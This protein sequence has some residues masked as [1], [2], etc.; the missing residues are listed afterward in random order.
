M[1]RW[2]RLPAP[3]KLN[4]LL[5]IT[6]RRPDGYHLL[7]SVIEPIDWMDEVRLRRRSDG[8]VLRRQGPRWVAAEHD[9][10]VRAARLLQA[11]TGTRQGVE[12]WIRK[13]VPSGAGLGGGSA[14]AAAVLRGLNRLWKLGLSQLQLEQLGLQLGTDLPALLRARPVWAQ[15]LGEQL[16]EIE[17]P[18]RHYVVLFPGVA[19]ATATMYQSPQL[20]RDSPALDLA[21]WQSNPVFENAFEPVLR[22]AEPGVAAALDWLQQRLPDARLT[23]SGSALFG[24]ASNRAAAVAIARACP[25][26]W[27]VRAC[28]SWRKPL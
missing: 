24:T 23:G 15:H 10:A 8:R 16:T 12:L 9:L 13:R 2:L 18:A 7:Q 19:A 5:Q 27:Q 26:A 22:A 20:V 21:Q 14:D 25:P 4:L 3:A 1:S 11:S 17:L 28:R 6:G